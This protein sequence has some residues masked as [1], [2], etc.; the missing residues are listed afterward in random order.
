MKKLHIFILSMLCMIM[1][2]CGSENEKP[3]LEVKKKVFE[4]STSEKNETTKEEMRG[5]ETAQGETSKEDEAEVDRTENGFSYVDLRGVEFVFCSGAGAWS[6]YLTISEDGSFEGLYNDSDMGDT[7]EGYP[8][9]TRYS[10]KFSGHLSKLT[11]TD[12][13]TYTAELIDIAYEEPV[14]KEEYLDGV[15]YIY[16][17]AYGLDNAGTLYFYLPGTKREDLSEDCLMWVGQA[18]Y[19]DAYNP[20]DELRFVCL[21]NKDAEE[22]FY[23]YNVV[24]NFLR[25]FR[26]YEEQEKE[27]LDQLQSLVT[28]ME[29]TENAYKRFELW[30]LA[31]NEEWRILMKV[32]S[33]EEKE[34][35]RAEE[36]EWVAQ[37]DEAVKEAGAGAEGGSMQPM[38]ENDAAAEITKARV[39]ELKEIL[40]NRD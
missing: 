39:Y 18:M 5:D 11:K 14:G 17:D 2:G 26:F 27:Y 30:D 24:E 40:E 12:D 22:A 25:S 8:N 16:S 31:L 19:D 13:L 28:Q 37:K 35:L 34:K 4:S 1:S 3:D 33:P 21:Y 10:C 38:L 6:T 32:L 23:S 9:G 29:M 36:R 7:G 20:V 15:R